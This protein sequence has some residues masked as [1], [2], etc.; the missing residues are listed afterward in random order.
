VTD[1]TSIHPHLYF[2]AM[3]ASKAHIGLVIAI[4]TERKTQRLV[5]RVSKTHKRLFERAAA[6]EGR[7]VATFVIA[8]AL[9]AANQLI[10]AQQ[11]IRLNA[12]QSH[13]FAEALLAEP[14]PVPKA[15]RQAHTAYRKRV[16]SHS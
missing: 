12:E 16:V 5:A 3:C 14:G 8:H 15:L 4:T 10:A 2:L 9:E 11:T 1:E 13:R 6:I 7:S